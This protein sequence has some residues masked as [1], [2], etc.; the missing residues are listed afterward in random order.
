MEDMAGEISVDSSGETLIV[1][2]EAGSF[3]LIND[4]NGASDRVHVGFNMRLDELNT[5][6]L[7]QLPIEK[8]ENMQA[9]LNPTHA[10]GI[11]AFKSGGA[12]VTVRYI[13]A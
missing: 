5:S 7:N 1:P 4:S 11:I 2:S 8:D 6:G 12:A 3:L 10:V 9:K 13:F